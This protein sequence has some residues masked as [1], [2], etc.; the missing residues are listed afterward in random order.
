MNKFKQYAMYAGF[1]VWDDEHWAPP[2]RVVDWSCDYEQELRD[3]YEEI[4]LNAAQIATE[5]ASKNVSIY[6]GLRN[7]FELDVL[8]DRNTN[9]FTPYEPSEIDE[10]N[11][12][13]KDC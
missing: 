11:D 5:C 4:V 12:Y 6:D 9:D 8:P 10:W 3:F 13:D 2:G 7:H 1:S